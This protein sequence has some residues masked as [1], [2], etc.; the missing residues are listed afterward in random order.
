MVFC[1]YSLLLLLF[2]LSSIGSIPSSSRM[3]DKENKK[4]C[5]QYSLIHNIDVTLGRQLRKLHVSTGTAAVF[6]H[7]IYD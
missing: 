2:I 5:V 6:T 7:I 1:F 4:T 3:Q